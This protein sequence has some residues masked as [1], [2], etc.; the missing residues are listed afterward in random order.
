MNNQ[1]SAALQPHEAAAYWRAREMSGEMSQDERAQLELWLA[2]SEDHKRAWVEL[3]NALNSIEAGAE[4]LLAD[5]FE[6]QLNDAAAT[7]KPSTGMRFAFAACAATVVGGIAISLMIGLRG[8]EPQIYKTAIGESAEIALADG[9][10]V[11]L[12]TA[13]TLNVAFSDGRRSVRLE[14][15]EA[16]FNVARDQTRPFVIETP[17]AQITVTGTLFDVEALRNRSAVYVLSGAVEVAPRAGERVTLLAGDSVVIDV[18]GVA[19]HVA[20]FD[21][22]YMLAWRTGKVRFRE[23]PLERVVAELNRYFK[24]SIAIVDPSLNNLP[25][26]G[27]FDIQD[28]AT[29]VEALARAFALNVRQEPDR[30]ALAAKQ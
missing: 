18:D 26:T 4:D 17:Q 7:R 16:V 9:S 24:T 3:G 14:G 8:P 12:N 19:G 29:V 13:T 6:H 5:E 21:P 27:D 20:A 23:E 28:Q 30:I 10:M 2:H 15:G 22:N 11:E 1:H 25:V